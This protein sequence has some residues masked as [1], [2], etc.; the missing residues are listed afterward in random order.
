M[1]DKQPTSNIVHLSNYLKLTRKEVVDT[2]ELKG[3]YPDIALNRL[4]HLILEDAEVQAWAKEQT[5]LELEAIEGGKG[6]EMVNNMPDEL[7]LHILSAFETLWLNKVL[8]NLM[9]IIN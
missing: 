4:Q 3:S 8:Q 5:K 9:G 7:K 6:Y 1:T 2:L